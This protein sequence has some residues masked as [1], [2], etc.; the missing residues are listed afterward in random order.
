MGLSSTKEMGK[1]VRDSLKPGDIYI[2]NALL[3]DGSGGPSRL[4]SVHV[5]PPFIMNIIEG[6][7]DVPENS[8]DIRIIDCENGKWALT[9]GFIDM[10]A[11]SD[12][13]LLHTP[14]HLA[15]ITQGVTT[16]VIGQDGISYSPVNDECLAMIRTQIAGWN[17]N[18]DTP[19]FFNWRTVS[20]YLDT[21]DD[22]KTATN[23]AYL[24]PQGNLRMLVLGY[25]SRNATD[26]E[27]KDMQKLLAQAM[28]DGAVGMSSGLTYVPGMYAP[29]SELAAL[30]TVVKQYGGYYSPH[31]RSYGK[32]ALQAYK[33]MIDLARHTGIRLHFT[34]A[35]LN[36]PE[37]RGKASEFLEM[38]EQARA[39]GVCITL[40][41]Y[42][43]L[44]GCTT[45]VAL[46]PSWTASGGPHQTLTLL[47]NKEALEDIR[48]GVEVIG[49]DGC[50]G[51]TIDW[52]AI[53]ISGVTNSSLAPIVGRTLGQLVKD[54][55]DPSNSSE[56]QAAAAA[57]GEPSIGKTGFDVMVRILIRDNLGTTIL[58]HIGHEG[59]VRQI[60]RDS[61]HCGGSDGIIVG[62]K[63]HPRAWGTFTRYLG[64]YAREL[65]EGR[66]RD[67][68][69]I[70]SA[71]TKSQPVPYREVSPEKVFSGGLEEA[72]AHL[73]SRPAAV[74]RL[75]DRGLISVGYRADLVLLDPET[76][77]DQGTFAMPQQ[78][79]VGIRYVF[80][81]GVA[82]IEEGSPTEK[83]A[84]RTIRLRKQDND[85][86]LVA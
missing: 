36:F 27:I 85:S 79:S 31:H 20:E 75:Q 25:D 34:H 28:E 47:E 45:L 24:V 3:I 15:K 7:S 10:H 50:H 77:R 19:G 40:D 49:T 72:V 76:V 61:H 16:E 58:Q 30:L 60:M 82:A 39:D 65:P 4:A 63:P 43:Y 41:T 35:T 46:L 52:D 13:N 42:P 17:G 68:Y 1:E 69:Y 74:I 62:T 21:L 53:E 6:K 64:H 48:Y 44:P 67:I 8:E 81:N 73:T 11:H 55:S 22:R 51:C 54:I 14:A 57:L 84:G 5:R 33:E 80:V 59:N 70:P 71:E 83:R 9:P 2:V 78:A 56:S 86:W 66:E 23:P 38:L 37:N 32:G 12:L 29:D 26:L 18:P